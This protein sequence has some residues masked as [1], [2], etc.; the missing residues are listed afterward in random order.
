V[1]C[2]ILIAMLLPW[3]LHGLDWDL[4]ADLKS[5]YKSVKDCETMKMGTVL[6]ELAILYNHTCSCRHHTTITAGNPIPVL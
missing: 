3:L 4:L 1:Y 5:W 2:I 6:D